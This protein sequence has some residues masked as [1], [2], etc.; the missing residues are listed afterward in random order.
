MVLHSGTVVEKGTHEE[1]L[2]ARGRYTS[3][4]EKQIRAERALDAAR[5]AHLRAARAMRR[6]NMRGKQQ[7]ETPMDGYKNLGSTATLNSA[8][9][10]QTKGGEETTTSASSASSD[11]ESTHTHDDHLGEQH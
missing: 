10:S 1:L 4:W 5:E 8:N 2:A 9:T 11:V 3:M 6:A 7:T